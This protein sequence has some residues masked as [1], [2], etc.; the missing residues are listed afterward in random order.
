[1]PLP[2]IVQ[3]GR[4]DEGTRSKKWAYSPRAHWDGGSVT[5][6]RGIQRQPA[7][8]EKGGGDEQ[9][10]WADGRGHFG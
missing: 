8:N 2:T 6:G 9:G 7:F 4:S 3:A 5:D 10:S 1:M